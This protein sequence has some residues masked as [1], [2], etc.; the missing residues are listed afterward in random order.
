MLEGHCPPANPPLPARADIWFLNFGWPVTTVSTSEPKRQKNLQVEIQVSC[1][2]F[3]AERWL[4][5][6]RVAEGVA[7]TSYRVQSCHAKKGRLTIAQKGSNE[8]R[9]CAKS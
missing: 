3:F 4:Y 9:I 5:L 6:V 8:M 1:T 2:C 7:K